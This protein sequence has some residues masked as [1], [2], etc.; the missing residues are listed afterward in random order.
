[1]EK[2]KGKHKSLERDMSSV[3]LEGSNS[4]TESNEEGDQ[5]LTSK[6]VKKSEGDQKKIGKS[7]KEGDE[8]AKP[9]KVVT[10]TLPELSEMED[11]EEEEDGRGEKGKEMSAEKGK[12]S[13]QKKAGNCSSF[14]SG[15]V[16]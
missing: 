10:P 4:E 1:M 2:W 8:K 7:L 11:P 3:L 9:S 16:V 5:L 15:S 13:I 6:P 12:K 14:S